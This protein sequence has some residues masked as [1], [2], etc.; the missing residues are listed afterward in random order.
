M[1]RPR[2]TSQIFTVWSKEPV[3]TRSPLLSKFKLTICT[4]KRSAR[5]PAKVER[6]RHSTVPTRA[7]ACTSHES[8]SWPQVLF[9][10]CMM[11][12]ARALLFKPKSLSF[13]RLLLHV[14]TSAVW[15]SKVCK[16]SPVS[17]SQSRA[18]LSMLPVATTVP[19]G[20][21]LRHTISVEWPRNVWCKSPF[22]ADHSLQV[23]SGVGGS[24]LEER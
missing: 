20:L 24:R 12:S 11:A 14:P 21:K 16:H 2:R 8:Q 19:C 18:V 7:R 22:S 6:M 17:T 13:S 23:L 5:T 3:I 15:P 9:I 10:W 4:R 1:Q